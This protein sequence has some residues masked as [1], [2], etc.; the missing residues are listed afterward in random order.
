SG[1]SRASTSTKRRDARWWTRGACESP[2]KTWMPGTR[3]AMTIWKAEGSGSLRR[4]DRRDGAQARQHLGREQA[5]ALRGFV[6][7]HEAGAADHGEMAEAADLVVEIHDL[8]I[9]RLGAAGEQDALRHGALGRDADQRRGVLAR[10]LGDAFLGAGRDHGR[11]AAI[12]L[13]RELRRHRA[14]QEL[15]ILRCRAQAGV[16]EPQKLAAH[17]HALLVGLAD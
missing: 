1:L 6:M 2:R 3:P 11:V 4:R 16:E 8:A 13:M 9:D 14:G 17:P 15:R 5:D 7:G 12:D 10:A